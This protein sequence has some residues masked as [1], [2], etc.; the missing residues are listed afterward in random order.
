[1]NCCYL[2]A[3][4]TGDLLVIAKFLAYIM[5]MMMMMMMIMALDK[6]QISSAAERI[7]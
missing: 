6:T 5:M 3:Q 2:C 1:M 7:S 4:L